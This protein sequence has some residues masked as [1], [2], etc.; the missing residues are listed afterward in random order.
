[1]KVIEEWYDEDVRDDNQDGVDH[2]VHN[3][4]VRQSLIW[5]CGIYLLNCFS[6]ARRRVGKNNDSQYLYE[7][8]EDCVD[9][10]LKHHFFID[11][12]QSRHDKLEY[13]E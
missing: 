4:N 12:G 3:M 9:A 11:E 6:N 7:G 10:V 13:Y 1:M 5:Q 8:E 2:W